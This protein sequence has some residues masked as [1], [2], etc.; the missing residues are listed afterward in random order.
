[1]A[2]MEGIFTNHFSWCVRTVAFELR[3]LTKIFGWLVHLDTSVPD[4]TYN[5][6]SGTLNPTQSIN[7]LHTFLIKFESQG[8]Q[9]KFKLT[10]AEMLLTWLL[11]LRVMAF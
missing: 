11:Q 10:G 6:F 9:S 5:V 2:N 1:M 3:P 7:H 8:N 4:M